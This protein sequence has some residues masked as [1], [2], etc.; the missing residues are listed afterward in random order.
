MHR[1]LR[2]SFDACLWALLPGHCVLCDQPSDRRADLCRECRDA[3][4]WL[5]PACERCGLP[6]NTPCCD[7]CFRRPPPHDRAV[8]PLRYDEPLI[9]MI[10][11]VKFGGSRVDARILGALLAD[12]VLVAYANVPRPDAIVPVPLSRARLWRRGHNQAALLAHRLGVALR[13]AVRYDACRRIRHTPP[14]A[15]LSRAARLR[16]LAG[17]FEV[18]ET[19]EGRR[20]AIV[21]DV[22]TTGSTVAEL[23][24]ALAS[25]GALSVDVWCVAR[26]VPSTHS[27]ARTRC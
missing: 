3:L 16:N 4:P 6:S 17:A 10:H 8:V 25:A 12:H 22:M 23:A 1:A 15:G 18:V 11:R 20:V 9:R 24:R 13:V 14:Q 5:G 2:R 26:T 27:A 19:F 7:E 21:D